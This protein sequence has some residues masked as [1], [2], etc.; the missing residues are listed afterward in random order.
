M[1][2]GR[3]IDLRIHLAVTAQIAGILRRSAQP[4]P[5]SDFEWRDDA[6]FGAIDPERC[7]S[8]VR[9]VHDRIDKTAG[10]EP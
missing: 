3:L 7:L 5:G 9:G 1:A 6:G 8:E 10:R 4:L 2:G